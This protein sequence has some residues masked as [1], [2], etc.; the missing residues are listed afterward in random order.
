MALR[1]YD[2]NN[3]I[4]IFVA[5]AFSP[6]GKETNDIPVARR[7]AQRRWSAYLS[8]KNSIALF[9]GFI[10]LCLTLLLRTDFLF[11]YPIPLVE[12]LKTTSDGRL[13]GHFPYGEAMKDDL[14]MVYADMWI[15]KDTFAAYKLMRDAALDDGIE[16]VLLSGYRSHKLQKQIFFNIKS[17][18]NQTA[19]QRAKVSAPPGYSEHSTGYAID[20]GDA[21]QRETD[22]NEGFGETD[23]FA[24]LERN[25]AKYHFILS[26]P[27]ENSQGVSYEPWHWRFEGTAEALREF[28]PARRFSQLQ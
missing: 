22:F 7:S 4:L 21:T 23:A 19:I 3:I 1:R 13:L 27:P 20:L 14:V 17:T 16:L 9:I 5:R 2:R 18:R 24:W 26:F 8:S 6:R 11:L 10:F 28:E 15:H 25:A 12:E